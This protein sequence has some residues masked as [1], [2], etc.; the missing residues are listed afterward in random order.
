MSLQSVILIALLLIPLILLLLSP[1]VVILL[2]G[3]GVPIPEPREFHWPFSA[4]FSFVARVAEPLYRDI[5]RRTEVPDAAETLLEVGGG[6]GRLAV[7]LAKQYPNLKKIITT[8]ISQNMTDRARKRAV[9]ECLADRIIAETQDVHN[10]TYD[11]NSFDVV[12]SL[13]SMHHWTNPTKAILELHRVLKPKGLFAVID[14]YGKP[15]V[16]HIRKAISSF[17]NSRFLAFALWIGTADILSYEEIAKSVEATELDYI[18][19]LCDD[20]PFITIKGV[21]DNI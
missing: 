17:S 11:D 10:L 5:A 4:V 9:K 14:G 16:G 15:S 2:R 7:A 20:D 19:I 18:S 1:L 21:R 8:D 6:D 13:F 12:M 3:I